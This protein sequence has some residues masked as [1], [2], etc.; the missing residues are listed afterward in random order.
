M[1]TRRTFVKTVTAIGASTV[2]PYAAL[3]QS[4]GS[5]TFETDAG[6]VTIHPISHASFVMETPGRVIYN[7]PVGDASAYSRFPTPDLVL[8]THEHGDHYS[9]E[10]LQAIAGENTQLLVNPAVYDMLP[11]DLRARATQIANGEGTSMGDMAIEA[12]PAYNITEDRLQY[13]PEGRDNGYVLGIDGRRVYVAGDTEDID[14]MRALEGIDVAFLPMNLP[15]TM[16]PSEAATCVAAFKPKIVYPFHYRG[17]NPREFA[18]AL[19]GTPGIEVRLRDWY[20][21]GR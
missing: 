4:G 2:L 21:T 12:I 8:V 15:Y 10:T 19:A 20:G 3:A 6:A 7:D 13:H 18:K 17:Q 5:N 1:Q 16:T 14:E 11:E 9:P